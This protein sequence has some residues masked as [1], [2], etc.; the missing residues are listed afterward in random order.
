MWH[1]A[2]VQE[3]SLA[4]DTGKGTARRDFLEEVAHHAGGFWVGLNSHD[5]LE[6][7][8]GQADGRHAEQCPEADAKK[9]TEEQANHCQT[10][11]VS[12][13]HGSSLGHELQFCQA[14]TKIIESSGLYSRNLDRV[15]Q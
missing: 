13:F 7:Q 5:K 4:R 1:E 2:I 14:K 3:K 8:S 10:C 15:K 11:N 12:V 6:N 9:P